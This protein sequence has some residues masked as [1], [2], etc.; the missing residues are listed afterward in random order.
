MYTL[1]SFKIC[2]VGLGYVGLPLLVELNK[3]FNTIGFDVNSTRIKELKNGVDRNQEAEISKAVA[4]K[5]TDTITECSN[6][7][8]LL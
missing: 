1:K 5:L 8:S 2:V 4:L 3:K 6:V 7:I